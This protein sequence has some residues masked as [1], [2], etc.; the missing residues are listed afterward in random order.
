M[1]LLFNPSSIA[2]VGASD[3]LARIGGLP[4]RFLRHH[5]FPGKIFPVNPKYKKIA[6]LPCF[7]TLT[8]IPEPVDLALIGIPRQFVLEAFKQCAEKKVPSVILFSAGYAEMGE[9]GRRE[10][11]DLRNFAK[12][13]GIR[14]V[15]P[16]CI[17]II[18]THGR[19]ATSFTSGL[20]MEF[21][22]PGSIGLITQSGG[23]G[24]CIFTRAHDRSIGL[25]F[26]ISS[27]NELDLEAAD[28]LEYF[29]EDGKTRSIA[30]L[31]EDLKDPRKFILAAEKAFQKGK[32]IVALKV[33][34]SDKGREAAASH[35]GA[36]SGPDAIYDALFKQKC[37]SRVLD[38]DDLLEVANL[39]ARYEL[40]AGNR[41]AI[42][43]TSGGSGALLA[44][45][46]SDNQLCLPAP[47]PR[48]REKLH[49]LIPAVAGIANPMDITTQFMNDPDAIFR[50]LKAFAEDE[51]FDILVI[52]FTV[53]TSDRTLRVAERI[54]AFAHQLPKPLIV[55]WP[56]GNM[57]RQAFTCLERANIPLFF[58]PSR[59]LSAVGH[60]ARYGLRRKMLLT[61]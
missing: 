52:N 2:I 61:V 26:F 33:G 49:D 23:I 3:D 7:P 9:A 59:C 41:V 55:C 15:G 20:E 46:A 24:N 4:I 5:G 40:A 11:E 47:S 32:P 25:R 21:L 36:M 29:V 57:A 13:A 30:L 14:V 53:S 27:G 28:F 43:S 60:F 45:L 17:G 54:A 58:H 10:Q 38:I 1:D 16:N 12:K 37:I 6:G 50:Y 48:T 44:D 22:I 18:N 8:A 51:N 39:F 34:R 42:L 19:V 35:T 31:L 56:V